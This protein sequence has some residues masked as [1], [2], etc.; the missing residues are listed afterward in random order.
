MG[1]DGVALVAHSLSY[2][3][4]W[5]MLVSR[6]GKGLGGNRY[7]FCILAILPISCVGRA[8]HLVAYAEIYHSLRNMPALLSIETMTINH[9]IE[10]A[11]ILHLALVGSIR[12]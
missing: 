3:S 1:S 6:Y 10:S 2:E 7:R 8:A 5:Y 9:S 11:N 4:P 12:H